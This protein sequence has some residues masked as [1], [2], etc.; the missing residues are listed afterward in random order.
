MTE[1]NSCNPFGLHTI[2][3]YLIVDKVPQL[4]EFL[5]ALF[6]AKPRGEPRKRED[7]SVMHAELQIGDSVVMMGEPTEEFKAMPTTLYTY[8]CLLYTSPS[9]RDS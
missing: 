9:P 6:D 4:I 5:T 7:G 3:P 8:V 1:S 2:T